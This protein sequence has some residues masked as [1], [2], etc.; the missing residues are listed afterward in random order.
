MVG[1]IILTV[2]VLFTCF[3]VMQVIEQKIAPSHASDLAIE[4]IQENGAREQLRIEQT[5]QNWL[6]PVS[7]LITIS[8]LFG[9][10]QKPL[11]KLYN[12]GS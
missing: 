2:V 1:R 12:F 3:L 8:L 5:S 4:Q 11:K 10:W 9:I 7:C 6:R